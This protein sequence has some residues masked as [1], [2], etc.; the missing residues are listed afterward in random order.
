[1]AYSYTLSL[2]TAFIAAAILLS[3]LRRVAFHINLTDKP[4]HRKDHK[5][6]VPLIG[7]LCMFLA[8]CFAILTLDFPIRDLKPF[9]AGSM[10]LV[11]VGIL[12]DMRELPP[13]SR[14]IAQIIA[15]LIMSEWGSIF[16]SDL[17][18]L[19]FPGNTLELGWFALPFTIF[20][21]IGVINALNMVDGVDGLAGST[22]LVTT[23]SLIL[24]ALCSGELLS[25]KILGL[26]AAVLTAFLLF[27]WRFAQHQ[28][29]LVFMGDAGS[30]FLGF[31][32]AWFLI[33][34]AQGE[35]RLMEPVT[36]IWI[37]AVPLIDTVSMM[38]RRVMKG[39]SPFAADREHFHHLLLM[40]GFSHRETVL[41]I[42]L[43]S[44]ICAATGLAGHFYGIPEAVMFYLFLLLFGTYFYS[45]LRAW[46]LMRFLK[47]SFAHSHQ[48]N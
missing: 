36:A 43:V 5:G 47:R 13:S 37:F 30:M 29:A 7:G 23:G 42:L 8:L 41:I 45:T 9:F 10:I 4:D 15:A 31:T 28:R 11:M 14:F 38:L 21:T 20:A 39:R 34:S 25:A 26:I 18:M 19:V 40:A 16:L 46:K 2:F 1:M 24:L 12:D 35:G 44:V 32:L 33:K 3:S 27:N 17:G 48:H 6:E 22:S